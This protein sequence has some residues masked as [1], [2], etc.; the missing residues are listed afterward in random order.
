MSRLD[1]ARGMSIQDYRMVLM[2]R[3]AARRA[4]EAL[5]PIADGL[6]SLSSVGP[7]PLLGNKATDSGVAHT[8]GLPA[9]N[10]AT[11]VLGSP[12]IT[13]PLLSV[14]GMPVGV[15]VIGQLHGDAALVG[16]ARW[17]MDSI[18]PVIA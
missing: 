4:F 10:A 18:A 17:M 9:F 13:L 7:A 8:T 3:E 12:A 11:S 5:A 6:V 2:R 1:L 14:G 16:L 15:Q